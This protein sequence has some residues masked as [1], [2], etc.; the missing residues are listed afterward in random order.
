LSYYTFFAMFPVT[1]DLPWANLLLFAVAGYLLFMGLRRAF[2]QTSLYRGKVAGS[3]LAGL[4]LIICGLFLFYNFY[5][6]KQLPASAGSPRVGQQAPDFTLPDQNGK[7]VSLGDL[8]TS[9]LG[10][11]AGPKPRAVLLDFYRG[12]W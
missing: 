4:S 12:Y 10:R 2:R 6:S 5:L 3:I 9:P 8:L 1:R 11:P 7:P